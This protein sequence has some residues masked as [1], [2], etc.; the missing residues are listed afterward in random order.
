MVLVLKW[1]PGHLVISASYRCS[2][3]HRNTASATLPLIDCSPRLGRDII[4]RAIT[5]Q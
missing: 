2:L 5:A 4:R 3:D 1:Q